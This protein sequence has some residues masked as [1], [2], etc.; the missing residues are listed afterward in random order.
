M[1]TAL[2]YYSLLVAH[3]SWVLFLITLYVKDKNRIDE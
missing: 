1:I 2:L 3:V